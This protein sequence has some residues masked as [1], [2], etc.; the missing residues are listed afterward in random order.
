MQEHACAGVKDVFEFNYDDLLFQA[1][2]NEQRDAPVPLY[3]I[4]QEVC[5]WVYLIMYRIPNRQF[6]NGIFTLSHIHRGKE[7]SIR[8]IYKGLQLHL[9][10]PLYE[11]LSV[12]VYAK[13]KGMMHKISYFPCAHVCAFC[14]PFSSY[15]NVR[16]KY[17][18][19]PEWPDHIKAY[20]ISATVL[21]CIGWSVSGV[22]S[23]TSPPGSCT[24]HDKVGLIYID[25]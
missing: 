5:I 19:Q 8:P 1:G 12:E 25:V 21:F 18:L 10:S 15:E 13:R 6:D 2:D 11:T 16:L 22:T 9:L 23:F 4:N 14:F 7:I 3:G 24:G 20:L 17:N